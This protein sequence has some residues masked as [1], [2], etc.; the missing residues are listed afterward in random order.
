VRRP[1][2]TVIYSDPGVGKTTL[3]ADATTEPGG[4]DVILFDL[5]NG[6]ESLG[7]A[8]YIFRP[9]DAKTGHVP[10]TLEEVIGGLR[11]LAPGGH[12]YKRVVIDQFE[13]LEALAIRYIVKRDA[14]QDG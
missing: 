11:T 3:G 4:D 2:R 8:R 1:R 12:P 7:V 5:D 13:R 14:P 6:S 10:R 9:Q